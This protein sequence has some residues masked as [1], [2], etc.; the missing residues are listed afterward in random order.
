M[1]VRSLEQIIR[2]NDEKMKGFT[3]IWW[4]RIENGVPIPFPIV[5][6]KSEFHDKSTTAHI[7][8]KIGLFDSVSEARRAGHNSPIRIGEIR[9]KNKKLGIKRVIIT[10]KEKVN[11]D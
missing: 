1:T 6:D 2:E 10:E 4:E 9:F 8:V 7:A 11:E 5:V 3:G